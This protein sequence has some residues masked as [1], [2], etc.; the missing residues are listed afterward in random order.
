MPKHKME[1]N[2]LNHLLTM[3]S[4]WMHV[5]LMKELKKAQVIDL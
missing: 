4:Y 2:T 1:S 3:D 5:D